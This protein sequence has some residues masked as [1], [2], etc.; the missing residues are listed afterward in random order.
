[1][2]FLNTLDIIAL[3]ILFAFGL[4][5]IF[6]IMVQCCPKVMNKAVII[7]GC[8]VILA[9]SICLFFYYWSDT[10]KWIIASLLL[11]LFFIIALSSCKNRRALNMNGVFMDAAATM[12][13][14][15]KCCTFFYIPLFLAFLVG[16]IF[17]II[18]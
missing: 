8:V 11:V 16:F 18:Y 1:M 10:G 3:S 5:L 13:G 14:K 15:S 17:M 6:M 7:L 2:T 4:S 9:L 12:L